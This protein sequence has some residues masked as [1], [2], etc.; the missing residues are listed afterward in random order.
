MDVSLLILHKVKIVNINIIG[1]AKVLLSQLNERDYIFTHCPL[2]IPIESR[3]RSF[4]FY[5]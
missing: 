2:R 3:T 4:S 5:Y 1:G